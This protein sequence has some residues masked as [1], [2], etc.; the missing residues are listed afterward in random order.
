MLYFYI[1]YF[2]TAFN[3][4]LKGSTLAEARRARRLVKHKI[5][6][7]LGRRRKF[8][9]ETLSPRRLQVAGAAGDRSPPMLS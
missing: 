6:S 1:S 4:R 3:T 8:R 7:D 9:A 5:V 2:C